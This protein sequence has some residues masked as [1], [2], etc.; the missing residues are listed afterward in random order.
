MYIGY[1]VGASI[2]VL[3][4]LG[5][6]SVFFLTRE[7]RYSRKMATIFGAISFAVLSSITLILVKNTPYIIINICM[8]LICGVGAYLIPKK[9]PEKI[10]FKS[11]FKKNLFIIL[12]LISIILIITAVLTAT[13][14]QDEN[15]N[16]WNIL[17][18]VILWLGWSSIIGSLLT[19]II[20]VIYIY[21]SSDRDWPEFA[22]KN[23]RI[24]FICLSIVI[25]LV[26][27]T[28]LW[29]GNDQVGSVFERDNYKDKLYYANLSLQ[30]DDIKYYRVVVSLDRVDG[31]YK[32]QKVYFNQRQ[33]LVVEDAWDDFII[34]E[35]TSFIDQSDRYWYL[36]L[37]PEKAGKIPL[38]QK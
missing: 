31:R 32:P 22:M 5:L 37:T 2:V 16:F 6:Y 10:H 24:L 9:I 15:T 27:G 1:I 35:K 13:Q 12:I 29:Y 8:A 38:Y 34:G 33:Y 26:A 25:V 23:V 20:Y 28:K 17:F 21:M 36:E 19:V 14:S 30:N 18:E 7:K 11:E 4:I 3:I